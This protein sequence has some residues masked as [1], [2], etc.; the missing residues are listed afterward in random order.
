MAQVVIESFGPKPTVNVSASTS[1][2]NVALNQGNIGGGIVLVTN[3]TAA[4]AFVK[5]GSSTVTASATADT[6][7]LANSRLS[8][9]SGLSTHAAVILSAG[10]GTVYFTPLAD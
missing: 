8:I 9:D 5:F 7:V 6:P 1:S 10:T 3:A 4:I 2:A